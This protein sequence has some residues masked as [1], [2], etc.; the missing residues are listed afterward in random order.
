[1]HGKYKLFKVV[2][3]S[4]ECVSCMYDECS[5]WS[6]SGECS[7]CSMSGEISGSDTSV[8]CS[9]CNMSSECRGFEDCEVSVECVQYVGPDGVYEVFVASVE[10]VQYVRGWYIVFNM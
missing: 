9:V 4:V 5:V 6:M 3:V 7:V 2:L 1:M 10:C 8:E